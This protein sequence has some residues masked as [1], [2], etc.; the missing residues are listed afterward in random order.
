MDGARFRRM[1]DVVGE[2]ASLDPAARAA[3]LQEALGDDA[4]LLTEARALLDQEPSGVDLSEALDRRIGAEAAR[5][6]ATAPRPT[7]IGP[8]QILDVLGEGGMG[9]VYAARQEQPLRRDVA[10]KVVRAGLHAPRLLARFEAERRTLAALDH[11]HIARVLEAGS[12][13]EGLPYVVME[14]VHGEPLTQYCE[15]RRLDRDARLRLFV[16]V[17]AAVEYAHQRAVVHRDL[18]PSNILVTEVDGDALPKVIDFGVARVITPEPDET[19]LHT[20]VGTVVGTR[21]Y[22]SPEQAGGSAEGVDTRSDVYA[23]GV[24]LYELLTD[25]LPYASDALRRASPSELERLLRDVEPPPAR[26]RRPMPADLDNII[27][28]AMR[29][30]RDARYG[31]VAAL[32]EDLQRFLDGRPVRAHPPTW[33][34]RLGRFVSRHRAAVLA[35]GV[36]LLL[37]AGSAAA[38][39]L[40]LA[41]E[42]DRAQREAAKATQVA[43]FLRDLFGAVDPAQSR[44]EPVTARALVDAAAANIDESLPTQP[45]LRASFQRVLAQVYHSLGHFELARP[46]AERALATHESLYGNDHEEVA[47]SAA[48]LATVLTDLGEPA[49]A[50]PLAR[51]A[52]ESRQRRLGA[53]DPAVAA[54]LSDLADIRDRLGARPEAESLY[55]AALDIQLLRYGPDAEAV[56]ATKIKLGGLL[57]IDGRR[58]EAAPLLREAVAVQRARLG[59][60]HPRVASATRNLAALLRDEGEFAEADSLY[61]EVLA[62][63]RRVLGDAHPEVATTLSSYG[64]LLREMGDAEGAIAALT[65]AVEILE[66]VHGGAHPTLASSSHNLAL[67]LRASGRLDEAERWFRRTM[68]IQDTVLPA[69]HADRAFPRFELAA[70]QLERNRPR[71]AEVLLRDALGIRRAALPAGHRRIAETLSELGLSLARQ[72][73]FREAEA[74]L[75]E[76]YDLMLASEGAESA[77][78]KRVRE[79]LDAA[80]GE[81]QGINRT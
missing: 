21:E 75:R 81:G 52:L 37:L 25:T 53:Q 28:T 15:R 54:L 67:Q 43:T 31:S 45:D 30:D 38:F 2:L 3:R 70:L 14:W 48:V 32:R 12:T 64:T 74:A 42:R 65:E 22:M 69:G 13:A 23:L 16:K 7:S 50:E 46:L 80:V 33:R 76:A 8:Y 29:K 79:R 63:R 4:E 5:L 68:A 26:S 66:R 10:I 11:P 71:E 20:A 58:R 60:S 77:R 55:R 9:I 35:A 1:M 73:R 49:K 62:L 47:T 61:R 44:G 41:A 17:L 18:K 56:A 24:I 51:T 40:R 34:Y 72:R 39:T 78:T 57:R 59:P 27:G 19:T 36:S 6:D